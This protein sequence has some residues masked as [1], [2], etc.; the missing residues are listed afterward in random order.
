MT[1]EEILKIY[2]KNQERLQLE[3]EMYREE[4][5]PL[6]DFKG[7]RN[8]FIKILDSTKTKIIMV[9][10]P[11]VIVGKNNGVVLPTDFD[12]TTVKDVS[13]YKQIFMVSRLCPYVE[14]IIEEFDKQEIVY[15]YTFNTMPS[16]KDT[17][18]DVDIKGGYL[19]RYNVWPDTLGGKNEVTER[20]E[21]FQKVL[22]VE[23]E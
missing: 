4:G 14:D 1:R 15:F 22:E 3:V 8:V 6:M 7:L 19:I 10:R 13:L 2:D 20:I 11:Y 9:D 12:W 21:T 18:S 16:F 5:M 17:A 23:E